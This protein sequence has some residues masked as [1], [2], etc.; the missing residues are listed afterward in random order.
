MLFLVAQ[1]ERE[2][3]QETNAGG[4]QNGAGEWE[5]DRSL[6]PPPSSLAVESGGFVHYSQTVKGSSTAENVRE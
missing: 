4:G 1:R 5:G 2:A 6:W 3:P